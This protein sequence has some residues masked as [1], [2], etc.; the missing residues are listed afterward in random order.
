MTV[1][2]RGEA[3]VTILGKIFPLEWYAGVILWPPRQSFG[4]EQSPSFWNNHPTAE[5]AFFIQYLLY[6]AISKSVYTKSFLHIPRILISL[7]ILHFNRSI[8]I[9]KAFLFI[10]FYFHMHN[11]LCYISI[12][13]YILIYFIN[14][15]LYF[16]SN[17]YI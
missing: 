14:S 1:Y 7:H 4:L 2:M 3:E 11:K 9:L 15:L 10:A 17:T 6:T 16:F 8:L 5:T 12:F 13:S